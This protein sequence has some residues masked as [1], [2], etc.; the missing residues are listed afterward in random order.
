MLVSGVLQSDLVI[1]DWLLN[2]WI[3]T[4]IIRNYR[5]IPH[6]WVSGSSQ[7]AI[8]WSENIYCCYLRVLAERD[9]Q[10]LN[11]WRMEMETQTR[12]P[13][14]VAVTCPLAVV[15][16]HWHRHGHGKPTVKAQFPTV[17]RLTFLKT[18][19]SKMRCKVIFKPSRTRFLIFI[20]KHLFSP[21][22]V[23]GTALGASSKISHVREWKIISDLKSQIM[24]M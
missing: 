24:K 1:W 12:S 13:C 10:F 23:Q 17:S 18:K 7:C 14:Q 19:I 20:L 4:C 16:R 5:R 15:Q 21:H 3:W 11:S 6:P 8:N 9:F 2:R 22:H